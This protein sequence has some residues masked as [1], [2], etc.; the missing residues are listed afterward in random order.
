MTM[1]VN[2]YVSSFISGKKIE[3]SVSKKGRRRLLAVTESRQG[4]GSYND[5]L[6]LVLQS[7]QKMY[8][9]WA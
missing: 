9:S 3:E 1:S 2:L 8:D 6:Y 4:T 5:P 7:N